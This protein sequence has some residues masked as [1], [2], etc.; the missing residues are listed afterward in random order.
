MAAL[1]LPGWIFSYLPCPKC[2]RP[3]LSALLAILSTTVTFAGA[4]YGLKAPF[5]LAP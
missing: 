3:F 4:T 1:A 2:G 5:V